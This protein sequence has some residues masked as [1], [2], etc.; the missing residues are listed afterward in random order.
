MVK[1]YY[2]PSN[3]DIQKEAGNTY[4]T[5]KSESAGDPYV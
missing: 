2:K 5:A 4:T 3:Y 1:G